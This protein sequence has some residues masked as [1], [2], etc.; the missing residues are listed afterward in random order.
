ML[1]KK[2][3]KRLIKCL[4]KWIE[5]IPFMSN[6]KQL[7]HIK[8]FIPEINY[9]PTLS[10]DL[11]MFEQSKLQTDELAQKASFILRFANNEYGF[12]QW[13]SP[14]RTRSYPY[15]RVYD[16]LGIKNRVTIIPFVK[17]EGFDGDRDF[18]QWDT[19]SLM[20][21]LNVFVIV[22]YYKSAVKSESY[23]DKITNQVYDYKFIEQQL[24]ELSNYQSSALHWN[25]KQMDNLH[26]VTEKSKSAYNLISK[27]LGVK[28]HSEKGIDSRIKTVGKSV[29]DFR[30]LS[31]K[32]AEQ[33]QN[34]ETQTTQPKESV[35][36]E[37]A[38]ITLKN[39]LGGFYY[40]T[41]DEFKIINNTIFLIEKK[42]SGQKQIPSANDV[43]DSFI[44]MALFINISDLKAES[45][46]LNYLPVVGLTSSSFKGYCHSKM[47]DERIDSVLKENE[48]TS[49]KS[50]TFKSFITEA[51][52]NDFL[53]FL[54]DSEKDE[55][56]EIILNEHTDKKDI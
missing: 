40:F 52:T 14:K 7:F 29:K 56:Q 16:T 28:M 12:S 4:L 27:N 39:F 55:Y 34:R 49:I 25:L 41:V 42:H 23:D 51:R 54:M 20:S 21:L 50:K 43:K 22:S 32:L 8:G 18:L 10:K 26:S 53:L 44:K 6:E 33:A 47:N 30:D 17:D 24:E 3:K 46:K 31:R 35:I 5:R 2:L 15:S 1:K 11:E 48:F 9:T 37:K 36:E 45:E 19:V 13:V 38:G